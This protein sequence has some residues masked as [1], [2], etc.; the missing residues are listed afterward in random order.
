MQTQMINFA[1]PKGLLREVDVLAKK[2][3][4]SRSELLREVIR[5]YLVEQNQ[6]AEDFKTIRRAAKK[7]DLTESKAMASVGKIRKALPMNK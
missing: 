4:R 3:W 6:R 7:T 2:E 5:R 1:I